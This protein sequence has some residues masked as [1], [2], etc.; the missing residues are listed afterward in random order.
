MTPS[1]ILLLAALLT[2]VS[3]PAR[4]QELEAAMDVPAATHLDGAP[5]AASSRR[6]S[7]PPVSTALRQGV[8]RAAAAANPRQ[9][10]TQVRTNY[11]E[12]RFYAT[13][14]SVHSTPRSAVAASIRPLDVRANVRAS[15]R[16]NM[17]PL[18]MVGSL[19]AP[20]SI[21]LNRQIAVDGRVS[22]AKLARAFEPGAIAGG[23][24]A[25]FAGDALG[26]AAQSALAGTLGPIGPVAGF[27]ARPLISYS[28]FLIGSN[29][30]SS[31]AHGKPSLEGALAQ[32]MRQV[33]PVR[34]AGA[35]VGGS[36]GAVIGQAI[37]PIPVVGSVVGGVVGGLVGTQIGNWIGTHGITGRAD[38][39]AVAWLRRQADRLDGGEVRDDGG[40]KTPE[41]PSGEPSS[42]PVA[43]GAGDDTLRD[44]FDGQLVMARPVV[45]AEEPLATVR[46]EIAPDE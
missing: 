15:V 21:E 11:R 7:L 31:V 3:A 9:L 37:I 24:A 1:R 45:A 38:K 25:G 19:I 20:V 22:P 8:Q 40:R 4:G 23:L 10:A 34:D 12:G 14:Y 33:D 6:R 18:S 26:A 42:L 29:F 30:G 16:N 46:P 39:G 5:A 28:M 44:R 13:D 36:V 2:T 17:S 35:L 27:V 32:S 41:R 43:E